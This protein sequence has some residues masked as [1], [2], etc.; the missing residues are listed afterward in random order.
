MAKIFISYRREDA[1]AY[2][3]RL[4]D[5]LNAA[6]SA[7]RVF[8]DVEDIRPGEDFEQAIQEKIAGCEV[9][10]AVIGPR[11]L[12]IMSKRGGQG[13]DF[14]RQE[15]S[16]ALERQ[17]TVIPVLVGGA[18]MPA[19]ADLPPELERLS[20][21][22]AVELSDTRFDRDV[23]HLSEL[24]SRWKP[25]RRR[26]WVAAALAVVALAAA[27]FALREPAIDIAGEWSARMYD[28]RK[29]PFS[30]RL[31]FAV[32]GGEVIGKVDYPTGTGAIRDGTL[33]G[34]QLSFHTVHTPQFAG[35]PATIRCQ[36]EVKD[37]QIHLVLSSDSGVSRGIATRR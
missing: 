18:R 14:V 21:R 26:W 24:L 12:E 20:R 34:K 25:N 1:A 15:L 33:R 22:N 31:T 28:E 7:D 17:I 9:V 4:C 3:G 8:M 13:D 11:W 16:A 6:L 2:A 35:E 5:R 23:A 36:G 30:I 29:R 27:F 19:P 32:N 37:Q 10:L